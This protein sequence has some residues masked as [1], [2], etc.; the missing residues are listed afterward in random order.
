MFFP[1]KVKSGEKDKKKDE[2]KFSSNPMLVL[3][4]KTNLFC[5]IPL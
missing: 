4:E 2:K 5:I 3:K 1:P